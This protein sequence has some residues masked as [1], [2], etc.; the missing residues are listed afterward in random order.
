VIGVAEPVYGARGWPFWQFLRDE[1]TLGPGRWQRMV[2]ITA[3]V[4]IVTIVSNAL[5]V[6]ELAISAFIIFFV[7]GTDVA[8]T[9]RTAIGGVVGLTIGIALTLFLFML[10]AAE[11]ALRLSLMAAGI[12]AFFYLMKVSRLGPLAFLIGFLSA[13]VLTLID[14]VPS[15]EAL[16]RASLWVWVC[17]AYPIALLLILEL[18]FGRR[19]E[20]VF[21][22]GIAERLEAA[23]GFLTSGA[24]D[25]APTRSRVERL[26]REGTAS[27]SKY[28]SGGPAAGARARAAIP[29]QVDLLLLLL[30]EL[31]AHA[32]SVPETREALAR[33]A[34]EC[35]EARRILLGED[36]TPAARSVFRERGTSHGAS[37]S[38]D[39]LAVVLPLLQCVQDLGLTILV[40]RHPPATGHATKA[41]AGESHAAP[42][43]STATKREALRFAAKVTLAS[44]TAYI[45]YTS[46]KWSGIHT[47]ILTTFFV[48]QDSVGATIHKFTLRIAGAIVGGSIGILSIVFILP[49]LETIG[50]LVVLVA[51]V[52]LFA[53]WIATGSQ[54]ISYAGVQVAFA[55]YLTVLQGFSR[56]S[57]MVVARDRVIGILLGNLIVYLV[58]S[59]LWPVLIKPTVRQALSHA[60]EAL[61]A[62][63]RLA[64]REVPRARLREAE[65][66]FHTN[67]ANASQYAPFRHLEPGDDDRWSLIPAIESLFVRIH[68]IVHQRLDSSALPTVTREALSERTEH[69][70]EWL[71][72]FATALAAPGPIPAFQPDTAVAEQLQHFVG[73]P[74]TGDG[75]AEALRLRAEWLGQLDAQ[76]VRMAAR[77]SR[78]GEEMPA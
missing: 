43:A 10:T 78:P 48:A 17:L 53:A 56:T 22:D 33:A 30:R 24:S 28:A 74:G 15:P 75:A 38:A 20:Q 45:L 27:L 54:A 72:D 1:L 18:V 19:T 77:E 73:S 57:K 61:A 41:A 34:Q 40:A 59:K 32:K 62:T 76:I 42:G 65:I 67:L 29:R 39:D 16:V 66:A 44:M 69:E 46:L 70:A 60:V 7:S 35:L 68:A 49:Q 11:P 58:F 31:P 47:A 6:P 52:T 5:R 12:F 36:P 37:S 63:L 4:S 3:L 13:Y 50:G 23:A 2:R 64:N 25:E 26:A 14:R 8:G 21:R 55:F 71:S 9:L 51:I